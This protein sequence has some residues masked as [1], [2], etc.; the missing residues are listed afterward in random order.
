MKT[1]LYF[2]INILLYWALVTGFDV[3]KVGSFGTI[4]ALLFGGIIFA[5]L[6]LAVEPVLKFF[7]FP[8][9]FWG[10][11]LVGFLLNL[12]YFV[13]AS[14]GVI[15]SLITIGA[16]KFGAEFAPIPFPVIQLASTLVVSV[17]F[18]ILATLLQIL[19]RRLGN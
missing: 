13:V 8:T 1:S 5:L 18:S 7:K 3:L 6:S 12:S 14:T 15:S 17:V 19:V 11:F 16:G 9:N 2:V 4:A 10:M